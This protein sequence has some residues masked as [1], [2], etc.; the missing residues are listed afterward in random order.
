MFKV[1]FLSNDKNQL[2]AVD[3]VTRLPYI[4]SCDFGEFYT[5]LN[6]N[7]FPI[8]TSDHVFVSPNDAQ[9]GRI[10]LSDYA[11]SFDFKWLVTGSHVDVKYRQLGIKSLF[12]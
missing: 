3:T 2:I 6:S 9:G 5:D 10:K 11:P 4:V 7:S 1:L 8:V 12:D